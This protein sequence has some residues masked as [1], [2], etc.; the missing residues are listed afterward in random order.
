MIYTE[1]R[2]DV[3]LGKL[4]A[5]PNPIFFDKKFMVS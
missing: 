4:T 5:W 1:I 3:V 2:T